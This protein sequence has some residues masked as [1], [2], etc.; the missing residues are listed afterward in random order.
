MIVRRLVTRGVEEDGEGGE[1]EER[2]QGGDEDPVREETA[3]S[4]S[5]AVPASMEGHRHLALPFISQF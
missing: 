4:R 2:E 5:D 1:E 3:E